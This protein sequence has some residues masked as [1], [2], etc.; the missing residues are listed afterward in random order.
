MKKVSIIIPMYN[1]EN[2]IEKCVRSILE[3]TYAN[4]EIIIVN[5]G[6][7]DGGLAICE[8]IA[9]QDSRVQIF[10][11]ENKGVSVARNLGLKKATGDAVMFVDGDDLLYPQA[12]ELAVADFANEDISFSVFNFEIVNS[13]EDPLHSLEKGEEI[14]DR[15]EYLRRFLKWQ[16]NTSAGGKLYRTNIAKDI[17]FEE[18]KKINEDRDFVVQYLLKM[19][20]KIAVH[21]ASIYRV[22]E[23]IGSAGRTAF[24]KRYYAMPYFADKIK[25]SVQKQMPKLYHEAV[26]N[27]VMTKLMFLKYILRSKKYKEEKEVFKKT[28]KEI[29]QAKRNL[30]TVKAIR[31]KIECAFLRLGDFW[32]K[33]FVRIY[34]KINK[35][36]IYN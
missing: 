22:L 27:E 6:S 28:K 32:Y 15:E 29:L 17:V 9:K 21:K 5:D 25:D 7:K 12:I 14:L 23:R 20:G 26:F 3:Q 33:I 34:D 4:L 16:T 1:L 31:Q 18:E 24:D 13:Q 36:K 19:T 10:S 8:S 2:Y 35:T 30:G 11:Q